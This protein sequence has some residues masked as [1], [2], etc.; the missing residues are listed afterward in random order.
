MLIN[1]TLS[2]SIIFLIIDKSSIAGSVKR[3]I[4]IL[5]H[6]S[7]IPIQYMQKGKQIKKLIYSLP[8]PL[9]T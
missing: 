6:F 5:Y 9:V 8:F 2:Q 7:I 1:K 3:C 4:S